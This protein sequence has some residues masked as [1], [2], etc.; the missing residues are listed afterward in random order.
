MDRKEAQH[1]LSALRPDGPE[2][3]DP[4]FAEALARMESDPALK[5]WWQAQQEFDRKISAKLAGVPVPDGL[6][7]NI[8]AR[9]KVVRFRPPV[10]YSTLLAAAAVLAFLCVAATF[11][12]VANYGPVDRSDYAE[13]ILSKLGDKGPSLALFS[14]DHEQVKAWLKSQNAPLGEMPSKFASVPSIGCQKYVIHG[15]VVSLICF[16][17][18]DGGEAHLFMVDKSALADPPGENGAQFGNDKGWNIACWSDSRMT[19]IVATQE[20]LDNLKQLL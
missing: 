10:R 8:L 15:H 6:R 1:I 11:W 2:A 16:T 17:L 3:N 4:A 7:E 5:A 18:A 12:H 19:Y 20:S 9:R 13:A 14:A